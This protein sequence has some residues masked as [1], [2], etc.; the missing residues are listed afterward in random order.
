MYFIGD[1]VIEEILHVTANKLERREAAD[2]FA[3]RLPKGAVDRA[4][5]FP[6]VAAAEDLAPA[7]L[8]KFRGKHP[9]IV[10]DQRCARVGIDDASQTGTRLRHRIRMLPEIG[11]LCSIP[12]DDPEGRPRADFLP[13][14][15][16][17][18]RVLPKSEIGERGV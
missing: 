15:A 4:P 6:G 8:F 11:Q 13:A 2:A 12:A 9:F 1:A 7:Y 18:F 16:C 14:L 10:H 3:V 5:I 17:R